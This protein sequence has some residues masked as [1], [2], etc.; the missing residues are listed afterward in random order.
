MDEGILSILTP[1]V[2]GMSTGGYILSQCHL[3]KISNSLQIS[4]ASR[5]ERTHVETF[6]ETKGNVAC[7]NGK[8]VRNCQMAVFDVR[9]IHLEAC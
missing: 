3:P 2:K 7:P 9:L 4:N 6:P 8:C 1:E 5:F